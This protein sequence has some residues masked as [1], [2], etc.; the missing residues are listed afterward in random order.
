M[1]KTK[2]SVLMTVFNAENFLKSSIRSI[3]RQSFLQWELII[4]DDCSKDNSLNIIKS[5]KN[6]KIKVYKLKRHLGRT[7]ALNYGI[8]KCKGKYIAILDADDVS[9]KNRL[10]KQFEFLERNKKFKMASSWY[11][12][13]Y[14][15]KNSEILKPSLSNNIFK[16]HLLINPIAHSSVMFLRTLAIKLGKYPDKLKYAQDWGLILKFLKHSQI[17]ILPH[18]LTDITIVN[19]SMTFATKYKRIIIKDYIENLDYV[20]KNFNLNFFELVVF[21]FIL[22]KNKFKLFLIK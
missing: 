17:K 22:I 13:V 2:I 5:F 21:N 12:I 10:L 20:R 1:T 16:K 7:K 3:I 19:N 8:K 14:K 15:D 6:K 4:I 9:K 18:Y 11:K